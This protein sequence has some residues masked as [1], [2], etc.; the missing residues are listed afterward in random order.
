MPSR[1]DRYSYE[2]R[3]RT[4]RYK[5]ESG[6]S[7]TQV[8]DSL[9]IDPNTVCRWVRDYRINNE[10]PSYREERHYK[11]IEFEKE[12]AHISRLKSKEKR[13][14]ELEEEVKLLKKCQRIFMQP[15]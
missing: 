15:Q 4:V 5:F 10:L 12:K 3:Q 13:I 2:D 9:G 11:A 7:A 1:N 6:K 8:A 14:I